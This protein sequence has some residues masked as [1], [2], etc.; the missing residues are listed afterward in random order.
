VGYRAGT[1]CTGAAG[2]RESSSSTAG[3]AFTR[4]E[5]PLTAV[6]R[7]AWSYLMDLSP[8]FTLVFLNE[9]DTQLDV[10]AT[11]IDEGRLILTAS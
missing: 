9:A 3:S 6:A 5:P 1:K 10:R 7:D 2:S 11:E 4:L 8:Y